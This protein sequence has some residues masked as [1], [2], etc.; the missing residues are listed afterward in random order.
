MV[1][2]HQQT[3]RHNLM[4]KSKRSSVID[5]L[6]LKFKNLRKL[7]KSVERGLEPLTKRD[8][9]QFLCDNKKYL[10]PNKFLSWE[11]MIK[12]LSVAL[13]EYDFRRHGLSFNDFD[14]SVHQLLVTWIVTDSPLF[15]VEPEIIDL[16]QKN[17]FIK[18]KKMFLDLMSAMDITYPSITFLFPKSDE[19][20]ILYENMYRNFIDF[21]TVTVHQK[22]KLDLLNRKRWGIEV[23]WNPERATD[24]DYVVQWGGISCCGESFFGSRCFSRNSDDQNLDSGINK[25]T[26]QLILQC[27]LLISSKPELVI[28]TKKS[29]NK[30]SLQSTNKSSSLV[31]NKKVFHPRVLNLEY[32]E[33]NIKEGDNNPSRQGGSHSPKRPHWR[34]GYTVNKPIGKMKGIPKEQWE[35]K[36]I[37]VR[38]YLVRGNAD[39]I[40]DDQ[41]S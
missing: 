9:L 14:F 27:L 6:V 37:T 40:T 29:F 10:I 41:I 2:L 38:P 11:E 32:T 35:R 25:E 21:I 28:T 34:L 33:K 17:D 7:D 23:N 15:V 1:H 22:E 19:H 4:N 24:Y 5:R 12:I 18:D 16:I 36:L 8:W 39:Q 30:N 3:T 13:W 20:G 31:K 26:M